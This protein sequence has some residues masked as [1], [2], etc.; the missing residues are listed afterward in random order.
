MT[1]PPQP[2]SPPPPP[3]PDGKK[4]G[5]FKWGALGCGLLA[6]LVMI[7]TIALLVIVFN[8]IKSTDLYKEA[9]RRA[10]SDPRLVAQLGTPIEPGFFV[11]GNVSVSGSNGDGDIAF[12]VS[13][14]KGKASVHAVA[15]RDSDG[16]HYSE[17]TAKPNHGARID[18]LH[19]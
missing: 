6:L 14:P 4:D 8:A 12:S 18:L 16:W 11:S 3:P 7:G 5:C 1:V 19:P 13:G 9:V 2:F 17:L 10:T 15:K